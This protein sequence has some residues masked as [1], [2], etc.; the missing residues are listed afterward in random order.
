MRFEEI[1]LGVGAE[2]LSFMDSVLTA[3]PKEATKQMLARLEKTISDV[4]DSGDPK[5]IAKLELELSRLQSIGG[6]EKIVPIEGI[7]FVYNGNTY[8]LTGA[9]ASANQLLGIFFNN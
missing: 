4:K 6:F 9:F 3:N 2:V 5:K 7:V 1:F 8:K